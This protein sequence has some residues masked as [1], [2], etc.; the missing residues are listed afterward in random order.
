VYSLSCFGFIVFIV[1]SGLTYEAFT[2]VNTSFVIMFLSLAR[3]FKRQ[4]V[5]GNDWVVDNVRSI[6]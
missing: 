4:Y 6:G 3:F 1:I 2:P 5:V